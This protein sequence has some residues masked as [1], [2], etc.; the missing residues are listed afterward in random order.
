M[1]RGRKPSGKGVV[2]KP[3]KS[4]TTIGNTLFA[5]ADK[6]RGNMD[7]AEYKH[8]ALGLIFLKYISDR[9]EM[10][11]DQALADP[12]ERDLVD[13]RDLYLAD[14]IFFV[15][16]QAR[17]TFLKDNATS[18]DPTIGEL[19]DQAMIAIETENPSLKGVLTK[20]YARQ[21]LDQTRLGEVLNLFSNVKF[22][23]DHQGQDILGLVYEYFLGEFAKLEGK[24]GGQYYTAGCVVKLLVAM[25]EPFK[26]RVYDP[27]CGSGGMFVQSERFVEEHAGKHV[28]PRQARDQISV[29]GQESNATTWRLAKMNLS[30]RG[31]E[32]NLG[33]KW[34]DT[35]HEDLHKGLMAKYVLAN[36][37][38][39]DSDWGGEKLRSDARWQ[40]GV[41]PVGNANFAW[42]QHI[43]HHLAPDGYAGVVLA[44]GSL[45]SQQS[46]EGDIRRAMIEGVTISES[47]GTQRHIPG[48]VD[49]IVALPSQLF[50]T[51]QIPV[52]LWFLTRDK[53]NGLSRDKKLRDRTGEILF[54]DARELGPMISRTQKELT[55]TDIAK[56]SDTYHA[57]REVGQRYADVPGFSK[58]ATLEEVAEQGFVLTPGRYVGTPEGD[59][60]TEPFQARLARLT[61]TLRE[62]MA[63][64][65]LLEERL[66]KALAGVGHGW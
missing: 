14:G 47:E 38:F 43:I 16:D 44:N 22:K 42:L 64:S 33:S 2:T 39:N 50:S 28:D 51:T 29:Y 34:G 18:T 12:E 21:E 56:V 63:T 27:C 7:A 52:C 65:A 40:F 4:E 24:R 20:N 41:P 11:R 58:S 45:S 30:I 23:D 25:L 26:G 59:D 54:V 3:S 36:P 53:S 60:E 6:L 62:Q 13:E 37:P 15:P 31:I 19:I 48:L 9:F 32:A 55:D 1:P 17:W 46:G 35:F 57:W 5:A 61:T 10:R 66:R 49:C 8:V